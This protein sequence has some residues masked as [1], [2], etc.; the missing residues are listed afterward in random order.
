MSMLCPCGKKAACLDSRPSGEGTRRRYECKSC[1]IR[2]TTFEFV[3]EDSAVG[4]RINSP[5]K[6][7]RL[8]IDKRVQ[9]HLGLALRALGKTVR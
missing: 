3:V 2:W 5:D 1:G 7:A 9:R 6:V 8:G 4:T